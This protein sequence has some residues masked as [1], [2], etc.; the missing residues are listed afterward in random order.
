MINNELL[1]YIR[2]ML[3]QGVSEEQIRSNLITAG[4]QEEDIK[5]GFEVLNRN[6]AATSNQTKSVQ[7]TSTA[8]VAVQSTK[9]SKSKKGLIISLV[10]VVLLAASFSYWYF[11]FNKAKKFEKPSENQNVVSNQIPANLAL[12]KRLI[13]PSDIPSEK[14]EINPQIPSY[15]LPLNLEKDI[16]NWQ[17]FSEKITLSD[18][19]K[20]LLKNNGFVVVDN[21]NFSKED[22]ADFYDQLK[23]KDLPVFITTD[24]LLHYYHIFFDTAL[25]RIEKDV[26]YDDIWQMSKKFF[27]DSLSVYQ[28]VSDPL[29]KEAA[30][31]NVAYLSVALELLKPKADQVV[32]RANVKNQINCGDSHDYY[33]DKAIEEGTFSLFGQKEVQ[34]YSFVTPDFVKDLVDQELILIDAHKGWDCSPIFFY[35]EDY[36]QYVP[37]GHYTKTEKLKN[38]F[39]ATMWYGRMTDLIN[40]SPNILPN[41][42]RNG[43]DIKGFVS[44][45]DAQIQTLEALILSRKFALDDDIQKIWSRIYAITSYFVGFSDDLGPVEYSATLKNFFNGSDI[46]LNQFIANF[47]DLKNLLNQL[48]KPKIYSGLGNA[49]LT[50]PPPPLTK[51]QVEDLKKQADQLLVNTQGFRMMGQRFVV[52]SG[53][54]SKIVSPYSGEYIGKSANKPFT[55]VRTPGGREVRGFPMGLDI[56]ALFGSDRAKQIIKDSGNADYSD[57][58]TQFDVLKKEIDAIPETD[59]YKNLYWN[60]FYVLKSL[61]T[62]FGNGYQ[63]FMQTAAWQDKELNTALASWTE[64]KHDTILYI[65]QGYTGVER[66]GEEEPKIVGYVEPIPEFYFRLLNLA[67]MTEKGLSGLL[68]QDEL[69][70][71]GI[72]DSLKQFQNILSRLLDIS[73]TEL[74]NKEL[75]DDDYNFI[76]YF[77]SS[78]EYLNKRLLGAEGGVGE[79]I[80]PNMFKPTLIAD[81]HTDGNTLKVLEEGVGYIKTMVAAYKLPGNYILVGVGPT[82]SYYE[83]KQPMENRLTDEEWR[84][85]LEV[86]PPSAPEWI[87]SFSK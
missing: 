75:S 31:R 78:L 12:S 70:K 61:I 51:E 65:K 63:S 20:N 77:G 57:Y 42:C 11:I 23:H 17:K 50:M 33:C 27:D 30:K 52:D 6:E 36:S 35:Q 29:L 82:F 55:Y 15:N 28:S 32:S 38:Y 54:F 4:W 49:Q 22:F 34:K 40:G 80:D 48:P 79:E 53:F 71:V 26:F 64:L 62:P 56:M 73:K 41:E 43:G 8:A 10:I 5:E 1:N 81:V 85:M 19:A 7:S 14:L 66:G 87:N 67:K 59:W 13:Q 69:E 16:S 83:F 3:D 39:K 74:Q 21:Q 24:S 76:S 72:G 47:N 68:T 9:K 60:W 18:E 46:D 86:N 37:R 25:T 45:K 84:K 44:E 2:A 58:E